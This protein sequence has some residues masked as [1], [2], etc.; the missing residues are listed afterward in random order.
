MLQTEVR[1]KWN[2]VNFVVF[3][4]ICHEGIGWPGFDTML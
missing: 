2:S 3:Y 4:V 1:K